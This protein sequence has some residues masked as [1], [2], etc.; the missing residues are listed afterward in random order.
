MGVFS[1]VTGVLFIAAFAGIASGGAGPTVIA[2]ILAVVL[3]F[4]W[5]ALTC[6][7]LYRRVLETHP[8]KEDIM[9]YFVL[10]QGDHPAGLSARRRS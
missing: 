9:R 1:I 4:T 5:L 8:R 2:F 10:A 6:I 3:A 7:R